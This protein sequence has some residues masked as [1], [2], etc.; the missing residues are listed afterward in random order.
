MYILLRVH[1]P[2]R[3]VLYVPYVKPLLQ[4]SNEMH[5]RPPPFLEAEVAH[6]ILPDQICQRLQQ[7][8]ECRLEVDAVRSEDDIWASDKGVWRCLA[9]VVD[10]CADRI[11]IVQGDIPLHQGEHGQ[12][13]RQDE[14]PPGVWA[15]AECYGEAAS[16]NQSPVPNG[17][18]NRAVHSPNEASTGSEFNSANSC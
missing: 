2:I 9:P 16:T 4:T 12:L 8:R 7:K 10:D 11:E 3:I 1:L 18:Q 6:R 15:A 13:V 17:R 14:R 5:V